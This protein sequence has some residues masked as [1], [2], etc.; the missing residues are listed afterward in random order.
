[1]SKKMIWVLV[2]VV[3]VVVIVVAVNFVNKKNENVDVQTEVVTAT[4]EPT[5]APTAEPATA[6]PAADAQAAVLSEEA[7]TQVELVQLQGV[8][9]EI[10]D[11]YVMLDAGEQGQIQVNITDDTVV[12]G[13]E[14]LAV[15][16]SAVVNYDGKMTRS[17]PAQ[18][19]ALSIGVYEVKGTVK[20]LEDGRVTIDK[21]EGDEVVLTLP[22]G[23][24]ELAVGDAV[25][26]Y[27]TGVSTMSLPPQMN[28]IAIMK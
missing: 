26:A 13:V 15:G 28:A 3:L 12:E 25:T 1:M 27:T 19:T 7:E 18:I 6:E 11:G 17:V 24:P 5:E 9:T 8:I 2:A 10:A 23:A 14:E 16:Q 4:T 20:A 22:E 21:G